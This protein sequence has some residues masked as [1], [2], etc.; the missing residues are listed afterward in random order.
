MLFINN[1]FSAETGYIDNVAITIN[2]MKQQYLPLLLFPCYSYKIQARD[3]T[4]T[5]PNVELVHNFM[6]YVQNTYK[7]FE[8][9]ENMVSH[10]L[11]KKCQQLRTSEREN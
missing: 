7:A 11:T 9:G 2:E 1:T 3:K 8:D 4:I 6:H 10:S 5:F